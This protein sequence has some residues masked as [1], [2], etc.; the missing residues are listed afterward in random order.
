MTLSNQTSRVAFASALEYIIVV[1]MFY[2]VVGDGV[3]A[4]TLKITMGNPDLILSNWM[5]NYI[6]LLRDNK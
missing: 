5:G 2:L 1:L 4:V 3:V 6:G